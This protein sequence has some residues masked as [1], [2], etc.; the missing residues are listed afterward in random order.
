MLTVFSILA[1]YEAVHAQN[2]KLEC[3][4]C[5]LFAFLD[6]VRTLKPMSVQHRALCIH[7]SL[8]QVHIVSFQHSMLYFLHNYEIPVIE[9]AMNAQGVNYLDDA[10]DLLVD[11]MQFQFVPENNMVTPQNAETAAEEAG[12]A[13]SE[14]NGAAL[15]GDTSNGSSGTV[16]EGSE[17]ANGVAVAQ[18]NEENLADHGKKVAPN[19]D[20]SKDVLNVETGNAVSFEQLNA[21]EMFENTCT[22]PGM[23]DQDDQFVQ[24]TA[25]P[26]R[27][28]EDSFFDSVTDDD[29]DSNN[30]H[31]NCG[32]SDSKSIS[33][34]NKLDHEYSLDEPNV[35][36]SN[37][38]HR[39]RQFV[40]MNNS[41][42]CTKQNTKMK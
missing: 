34:Y 26:G 24:T 30:P 5:I 23:S 39:L 16:D 40:E 12:E 42:S 41:V 19:C 1:P 13:A 22:S 9:A 36:H 10:V 6:N 37:G 33:I 31:L 32:K 27:R 7:C 8:Q 29:T 28:G 11:E 17:M 35:E 21:N 25:S 20:G 4:Q 15:E 18:M 14:A 38:C 3:V 2:L